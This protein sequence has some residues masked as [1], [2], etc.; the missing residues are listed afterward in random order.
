MLISGTVSWPADFTFA[1][2]EIKGKMCQKICDAYYDP[3]YLCHAGKTALFELTDDPHVKHDEHC[4]E[5]RD[6]KDHGNCKFK[7]YICTKKDSNLRF[8]WYYWGLK[9]NG[10]QIEECIGFDNTK[11]ASSSIWK[12]N[13]LCGTP[14]N[15]TTE[16]EPSKLVRA[17]KFADSTFFD[18]FT[19]FA[20]S[21]K[22]QIEISLKCSRAKPDRFIFTSAL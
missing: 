13:F 10:H 4:T 16:I 7:K 18:D 19:I 14:V 8:D 12:N 17:F 2:E 6:N 20:E 5:F 22:F 1:T 11:L 21:A 15:V 3:I 9:G